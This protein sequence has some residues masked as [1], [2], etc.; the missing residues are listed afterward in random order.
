MIH[1]LAPDN[2]G[3]PLPRTNI[4]GLHKPNPANNPSLTGPVVSIGIQLSSNPCSRS[5]RREVRFLVLELD[6]TRDILR[7]LRQLLKSDNERTWSSF[8]GGSDKH[9]VVDPNKSSI[10]FHGAHNRFRYGLVQIT[11]FASP[12]RVQRSSWRWT[13][14]CSIPRTL[15]GNL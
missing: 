13:P 5:N 15:M 1:L 14:P 8:D 6:S 10:F 11:S 2:R 12:G 4:D 3:R 7:S 9:L